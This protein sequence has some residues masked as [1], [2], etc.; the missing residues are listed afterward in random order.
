VVPHP[1]NPE[2]AA[3]AIAASPYRRGE[4]SVIA[5]YPTRIP[6]SDPVPKHAMRHGHVAEVS[7]LAQ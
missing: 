2:S 3:V 7:Q 4:A 6:T 5:R 1:S